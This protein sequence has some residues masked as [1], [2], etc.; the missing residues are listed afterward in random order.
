MRVTMI[1]L[2]FLAVA[3]AQRAFADEPAKTAAP[4]T[5]EFDLTL[6]ERSPQSAPKEMAHRLSLK[7]AEL[8]PDYDIAK[9]P[10][11]A[12]VPKN[13][14]PSQPYGLFV[15]LGYKDAISVAVDWEPL[16]DE[17][18]LLFVTPVCHSGTHFPDS[19][20]LWQT[21]GLAFDALQHFKKQYNLDDR[22]VYLMAATDDGV[23]TVLSAADKF[24]GLILS[25]VGGYP[26]PIRA[27]NGGVFPPKF[28]M[29]PSSLFST[30]KTR[31]IVIVGYTDFSNPDQYPQVILRGMKGD[32]FE[33]VVAY[34]AAW[35]PD[36]HY[37][38]LMTPWF[39]QNALPFIERVTMKAPAAH[40]T[41][42]PAHDASPASASADSPAA[43]P[44]AAPSAAAHSAEADRLL[45]LAKL[46]LKNGQ[47]AAAKKKLDEILEV[48]ANDPAAS[49]AKEL[50]AQLRTK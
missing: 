42:A 21:L 34:P 26:R 29:P 6:T 4:Q 43:A 49:E 30:A 47:S 13:Y 1:A 28:P 11:K 12:Y 9:R 24:T 2:L 36:L 40:P 3:M 7:P 20:P 44:A 18:R 46:Y 15:Y 10:F 16:L 38:H 23:R 5:G 37:P 19:V 22:R 41:S 8:G 32:G 45:R 27:S 17:H 33:H 48:Y 50:E 25:D 35:V 39:E 31:P 14:D